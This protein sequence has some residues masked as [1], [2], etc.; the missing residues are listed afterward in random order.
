M[1][2]TRRSTLLHIFGL[3]IIVLLVL[4]SSMVPSAEALLIVA[5]CMKHKFHENITVAEC[6]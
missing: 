2:P 6:R 5:S 3:K 4:L 1:F